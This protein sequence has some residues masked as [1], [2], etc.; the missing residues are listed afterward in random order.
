[1]ASFADLKRLEP[2][3]DRLAFERQH[4]KYAF[5]HPRQ[6]F[7]GDEPVE[8]FDAE[9]EFGGKLPQSGHLLSGDRHRP[10]TLL[11]ALGG[12]TLG[13]SVAVS[14]AS[15]GSHDNQEPPGGLWVTCRER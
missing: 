10:S 1:M 14:A 12:H 3:V 13:D 7:V 4:S 2:W 15:G 8:C 5:M 11:T 6:V 9:S